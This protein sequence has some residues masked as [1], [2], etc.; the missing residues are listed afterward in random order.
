MTVKFYCAPTIFLEIYI[1]GDDQE[2]LGMNDV[3]N[4]MKVAILIFF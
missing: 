2:Q 4:C 3:N 1:S